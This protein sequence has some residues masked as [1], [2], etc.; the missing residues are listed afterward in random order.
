MTATGFVWSTSTELTSF[1]RRALDGSASRHAARAANGRAGAYRSG[2]VFG[3]RPRSAI[4]HLVD[5]A[6]TADPR[7]LD[8]QARYARRQRAYRALKRQRPEMSDVR[9]ARQIATAPRLHNASYDV[10]YSYSEY[11]RR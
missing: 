2:T 9:Y 8:S 7:T 6:T 1:D 10:V 11:R 5:A 3:H 4:R